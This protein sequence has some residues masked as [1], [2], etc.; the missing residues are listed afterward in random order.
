[1]LIYSNGKKRYLF[2]VN[3]ATEKRELYQFAENKKVELGRGW[4]LAVIKYETNSI[5]LF[6]DVN[7]I[8]YSKCKLSD[9]EC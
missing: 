4:I 5:G 8:D 1:M 3:L 7:E 2:V 9:L 6:Y